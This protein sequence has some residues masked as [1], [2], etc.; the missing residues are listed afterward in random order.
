MDTRAE[1]GPGDEEVRSQNGK[2]VSEE[3]I[4]VRMKGRGKEAIENKG[5]AE[6]KAPLRWRS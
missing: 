4:V 2:R 3:R 6:T 1:P 5:A